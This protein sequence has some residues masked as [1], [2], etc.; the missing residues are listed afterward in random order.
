M[1]NWLDSKYDYRSNVKVCY[2]TP[3][4]FKCFWATQGV[5]TRARCVCLVPTWGSPNPRQAKHAIIKV[6][7]SKDIGQAVLIVVLFRV[8]LQKLLHSDVGKAKRIAGVLFFNCG[9][10]LWER[11]KQSKGKVGKQ[12][13][14]NEAD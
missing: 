4:H 7:V 1:D 9:I 8:E 10:D 3:K 2:K 14:P 11:V 6:P 5:T 13:Y 12:N